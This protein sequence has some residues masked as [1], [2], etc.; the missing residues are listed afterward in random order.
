MPVRFASRLRRRR[1]TVVASLPQFLATGSGSAANPMFTGTLAATAPQFDAIGSGGFDSGAGDS[2]DGLIV[3]NFASFDPDAA[4]RISLELNSTLPTYATNGAIVSYATESWWNGTTGV[5]TMRPPTGGD[6]YSGIGQINLWKNATK[7]IRQLNMR[8][9]TRY[10]DLHLLNGAQLPKLMILI[11]KR[12]LSTSDLVPYDR[13]MLFLAHMQEADNLSLHINDALVLTTAQ[14][15]VRCFSE[16]NIVPA[17]LFGAPGTSGYCNMR[18]SFYVRATGGADGAGNPIIDND[19]YLCIELRV[20]V[21]ATSDEP[22]GVIAYRVTRR[23]GQVFERAQAWTHW[24]DPGV[25]NV[26]TNYISV[27]D[28]FGGGYY[29]NGQ[30]SNVNLWTKVGRRLTF[31]FNLSP[32]TGRAWIGPPTGFVT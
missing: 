20:N 7:V 11:C 17:P 3:S 25:V 30:P 24:P 1:A 8:W 14:G 12:G 5:C 31:D 32:A 21:M 27:L 13:P 19:E 23:N 16:S 9:E 22:N 29:N 2:N 4:S 10:S 6:S 26:D 28:V 18:Q 15:T